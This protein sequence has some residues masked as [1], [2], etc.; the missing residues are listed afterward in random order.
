MVVGVS[1]A[2][3][4]ELSAGGNRGQLLVGAAECSASVNCKNLE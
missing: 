2:V 3:R 4:M 1:D